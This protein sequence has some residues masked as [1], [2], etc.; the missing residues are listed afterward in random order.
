MI[1]LWQR[2]APPLKPPGSIAEIAYKV[3]YQNYRDF[4]RNFVKFEGASPRSTKAR[5]RR[6]HGGEE[7]SSP[8]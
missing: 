8:A 6:L 7:L 3:G 5:L 2:F 1:R 4:Y